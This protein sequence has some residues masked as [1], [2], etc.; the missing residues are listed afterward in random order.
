MANSYKL[1]EANPKLE[2]RDTVYQ[3]SNEFVRDTKLDTSLFIEINSILEK[4]SDKSLF[5]LDIEKRAQTDELWSELSTLRHNYLRCLNYDHVNTALDLSQ[6]TGGV[7]H[8]LADQVK[9]LDS[10][11]VDVNRSRL[12][13]IRC[14]SK[15]NVLHGKG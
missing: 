4:T 2:L 12:S 14:A 5:S 10:I 15:S 1:L 11:K 6:D 8:Y 3:D 9:S 7:S 13:V